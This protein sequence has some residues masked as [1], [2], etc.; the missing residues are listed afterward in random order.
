MPNTLTL[1]AAGNSCATTE[2]EGLN[3]IK[4]RYKFDETTQT[5]TVGVSSDIV[6][7]G[8]CYDFLREYFWNC[9]TGVRGCDKKIEGTIHLC[10][11]DKDLPIEVIAED[12]EYCPFD[13]CINAPL[14]LRQRG[15]SFDCL[16]EDY[17]KSFYFPLNLGGIGQTTPNNFLKGFEPL[18]FPREDATAIQGLLVREVLNCALDACGITFC[19]D[20]LMNEDSIYYNLAIVHHDIGNVWYTSNTPDMSVC[21]VLDCLKEVLNADYTI[22]PL[23]RPQITLE[24]LSDTIFANTH[25]LTFE[26]H[27]YFDNNRTLLKLSDFEYESNPCF[28][29]SK[30]QS[31]S[32]LLLKYEDPSDQANNFE[33]DYF[34]QYLELYRN[35]IEWNPNNLDNR[36]G[37]CEKNFKFSPPIINQ[38]TG[39]LQS[40]GY[41]SRPT[42][43]IWDGISRTNAGIIHSAECGYNYP[44]YTTDNT[45][46]PTLYNQLHYIDAPDNQLI[47]DIELTDTITLKPKD[48]CAFVE[49]VERVGLN[50]EIDTE[51][52]GS[53]KPKEIEIDY[54][55]CTVTFD[56][57]EEN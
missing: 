29:Y 54:D 26:R 34:D 43:L 45:N 46:C 15:Q 11:C 16:K 25:K 50:F 38:E 57:L 39:E 44:L 37:S 20:L 4:V 22:E 52:C 49:V 8:S 24:N 31:C 47:C 30:G 1:Y 55:N 10:K 17:W 9:G 51:L 35:R 13:C 53:F 27:D 3:E 12:T 21:D 48:F 32:N 6:F 7:K 2:A 19:S 33:D 18:L 5:V 14:T 36:E 28:Q 42:L 56:E 23:P 40:Y 41:P